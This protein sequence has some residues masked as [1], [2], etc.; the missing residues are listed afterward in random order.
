[1]S[2]EIIGMAFAMTSI[3]A[4]LASVLIRRRGIIIGVALAV[5]CAAL[6]QIDGVSAVNLA[7]AFPGSLSA[8]TLVLCG[9]LLLGAMRGSLRSLPSTTFLIGVVVAGLL[10][11][12]MAAGLG[13]FDPY[14]L[15]YRGLAVP[16]LMAVVA[17]AGW[18]YDARDVS[19]WIAGAA[20]LFMAGGLTSG[21]LW[22]YLIDPIAFVAAVLLL[23][24][25]IWARRRQSPANEAN[26]ATTRS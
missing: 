24:A 25:R 17:A 9:H 1:M 7:L 3:A 11:Y 19:I 5:G 18:R 8:A 20:L 23:S 13:P 16:I 21:N 2:G 22:D 26:S 15:G 14:D 10:L 6:V 12:P 4:A